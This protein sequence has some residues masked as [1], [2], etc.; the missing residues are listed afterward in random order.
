MQ[1]KKISLQ[2]Q[3][4]ITPKSSRYQEYI[5]PKL[6]NCT[7]DMFKKNQKISIIK[8]LNIKENDT[9]S[10]PLLQLTCEMKHNSDETFELNQNQLK[11]I[12]NKF[13]TNIDVNIELLEFSNLIRKSIKQ[14]KYFSHRLDELQ[15]LTT[16]QSNTMDLLCCKQI[17]MIDNNYIVF[18]KQK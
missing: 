14:V 1:I 18:D 7:V 6:A 13:I 9:L 15:L 3:L 8:P 10:A 17:S 5:T 11:Q 4:S 2:N 16:T 12:F